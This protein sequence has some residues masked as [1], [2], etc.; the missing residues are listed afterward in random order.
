[1]TAGTEMSAT[2]R[3]L[4]ETLLYLASDHGR[5]PKPFDWFLLTAAISA[6][7]YE[8]LTGK[9]DFPEE[10]L[11]KRYESFSPA[12]YER[13]FNKWLDELLQGSGIKLNPGLRQTFKDLLVISWIPRDGS[14]DGYNTNG[15]NDWMHHM[16]QFGHFSNVYRE[17]HFTVQEAES[18]K[19]YI[20]R[21]LSE[22]ESHHCEEVAR[23]MAKH[24]NE[25]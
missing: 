11:N 25:N 7:L 19:E 9:T 16:I 22:E 24:I 3:C 10:F 12:W 15:V 6:A 5:K 18:V 23:L 13:D 4:V 1:M 2:E 20:D 17:F 21:E 8:Y 14:S